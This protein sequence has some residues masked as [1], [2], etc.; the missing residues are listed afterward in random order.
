MNRLLL[1]LITAI[2]ALPMTTRAENRLAPLET[3]VQAADSLQPGLTGYQTTVHTARI[4]ESIASMTAARPA[5]MPR[6]QVPVVVKYWRRGTPRSLIVAEG[7]QNSPFMQQ[8]VQ[9]VSSN[10]TIEP[11]GLMMPAGKAAERQRLA[12]QATV[13][14]TETKLADS[15]LQRV[16]VVFATPTDIGEAF[17]GNG[18][19]LP[20]KDI[21]KLQFDIDVNTRT[22]RELAIQTATGESL[23]AEI[24][25]QPAT[26]GFLPERVRV[27]SPDGKID[28]RLEITFTEVDGFLLPARIVRSLNRPDLKDNLEVTFS[29]YRVNQ[30]FPAEIDVQLVNPAIPPGKTP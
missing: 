15:V 11:E 9:R 28:D 21:V 10:L 17:Y 7:G 29:N 5:E 3:V 14:G 13:R 2:L 6:P 1:L 4:A 27:T 8:M 23:L 24:R 18:L 16:E 20:Q 30:P 26:G 22:V 25:Y 19:R 12:G